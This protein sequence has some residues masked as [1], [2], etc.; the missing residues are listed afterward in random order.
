MLKRILSISLLFFVATVNNVSYAAKKKSHTKTPTTQTVVPTHTSLVVDTTTGEVLHSNN[1]EAK[2]YPAS[3]TKLMTLY[4]L[5][6]AV[7]SGKLSLNQKLLV[8]K[9]AELMRPSKLGLKA[10]EQIAVRDVI[11]ALIVKSANDAARVAAENIS[12]TEANFAKMMNH[13]A[14]QLGM[15]KTH[16]TNASGWHDPAQKTTAK[17]L[18]KLA[19]A[20]KRDHPKFYSLFSK[21][22]FVFRG[23]T[24][25]GHNKVTENYQWSEGLKTGYTGPAGYNLITTAS[26]NNKKIVGVVTG[27]KSASSR[28]TLMVSLLNKHLGVNERVASKSNVS[29]KKTAKKLARS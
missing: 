20:I 18:A 11:M 5:F 19:I 16:F 22:S 10:G 4:L 8:S 26:R 12:G 6:E 23:A 27:G 25:K 13:K 15:N 14:K 28:D 7:D 1:A 24:I 2:V 9:N 21:T 29:N 3:L 17:D